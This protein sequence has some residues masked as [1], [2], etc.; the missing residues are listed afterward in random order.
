MAVKIRLQRHGKKGKPFYWIVIADS[1]SKRDGKY[2]QKLGVYDPNINPARVEINVE[3]AL[4]WLQNG[5]IPTNTARTLLSYRGVMLKHHLNKGVLK[6]ALNQEKADEQ[7]QA[8][9][10]AKESKISDKQNK[11]SKEIDKSKSDK[12]KLEKEVNEKRIL[13]RETAAKEAA[14]K[15][16]EKSTEEAPAEEAPVKE[17]AAKEEEKST[18]EAPAEEALVKEAAVKEEVAA[19]EEV[20]TDES[21]EEKDN[22]KDDSPKEE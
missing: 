10:K 6:G 8:W 5:A 7:F 17:A 21:L 15:E 11:I 12:L 14:A 18:E 1:R 16:E 3:E 4:K 22:S 2:L 20:P 19:Q 9:L 13:D